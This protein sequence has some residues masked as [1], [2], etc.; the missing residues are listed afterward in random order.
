MIY[1]IVFVVAFALGYG[2]A[3]LGNFETLKKGKMFYR[4]DNGDWYP[5]DPSRLTKRAPDGATG[6]AVCGSTPNTH[7]T[8][9]H[10]RT[11]TPRR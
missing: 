4:R 11:G 9:P 3:I 10:R 2:F 8:A 5:Y 7:Y 1:V 6:C